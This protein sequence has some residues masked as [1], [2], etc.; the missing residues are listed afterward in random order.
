MNKT[1]G[2]KVFTWTQLLGFDK[3]ETDKG[4]KNFL[5]NTSFV[6]DGVYALVHPSLRLR[7]RTPGCSRSHLLKVRVLFNYA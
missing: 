7:Y 4:V 5:E 6:P 2:G 3:N 1:K